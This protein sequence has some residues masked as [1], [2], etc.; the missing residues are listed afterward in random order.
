M[1]A[2]RCPHRVTAAGADIFAAAG[3]SRRSWCPRAAV[4]TCS[5]D[6]N[7][8]E[9]VACNKNV[10]QLVFKD[11]VKEVIARRRH[12][13]AVFLVMLHDKPVAFGNLLKTL[14]VV[15]VSSAGVLD[16]VDVALVMD[17]FM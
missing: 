16:A 10:R 15:G 9:L 6:R 12:R 14:V 8:I 4:R 2:L 13:P 3:C 11:K 1:D 17:H 5:R 7:A